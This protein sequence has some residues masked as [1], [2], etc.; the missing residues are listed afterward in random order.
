MK[1]KTLFKK[2]K[3]EIRGAWKELFLVLRPPKIRR[4]K[5]D[6]RKMLKIIEQNAEINYG[7]YS[8]IL[9]LEKNICFKIIKMTWDDM[10]KIALNNFANRHLN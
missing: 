5:K 1:E 6:C 4:I 3:R 10:L 7:V 9:L 8:R 2:C